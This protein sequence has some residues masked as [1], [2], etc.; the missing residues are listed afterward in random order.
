MEER[1]KEDSKY[2]PYIDLLPEYF[3]LLP[4][5][6]SESELDEAKGTGL[7]EATIQLKERLKTKYDYFRKYLVDVCLKNLKFN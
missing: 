2:K 6:W 4:I 1:C 5:R 3:E 7:R